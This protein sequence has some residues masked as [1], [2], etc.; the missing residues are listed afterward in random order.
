[1]QT[2][3]ILSPFVATDSEHRYFDNTRRLARVVYRFNLYAKQ[4]I[5]SCGKVPFTELLR[6]QFPFLL[7]DAMAPPRLS[8]EL[9]NYC[10][11]ACPYCSSPK[12]LR[13]RGV[14]DS[15]TFS[16]L[17][18]QVEECSIPWISLVGNGEPTLHPEFP[19]YVRRL[20]VA[21]K[22]LT[23]TTNW[24]RIDQDTI[25]SVLQAPVNVL[26]VSVDGGTKDEYE[27]MRVGGK[28]DRLLNNLTLLKRL[29]DETRS[30]T[31]IDLRVMLLPSHN[32]D[33]QRLLSFWRGYGD[34]VSRQYILDLGDSSSHGHANTYKQEARC[35]LPFKTLDVNWNGN[36]PLCSYSRRQ[37]GNPHGLLVGNINHQSLFVILNG[38]II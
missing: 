17:V 27:R 26:H 29:K 23:L 9:T 11:L 10:N 20:A 16:N 30:S 32:A 14:M 2:F 36:I 19:Q 33:D 34:L 38:P 18:R 1:M 22:F 25:Q 3:R 13:P 31:L 4:L 5:A 37:T 8:V 28:F 15:G 21:T 7:P 6:T 24:Q 12:K 35:T